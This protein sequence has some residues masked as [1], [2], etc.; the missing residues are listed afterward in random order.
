MEHKVAIN[1]EWAVVSDEQMAS[2]PVEA[3]EQ[4]LNAEYESRVNPLAHFL[5][6]GIKWSDRERQYGHGVVVVPPSEY[7]KEMRNDG[8]A[9]V[10]D[11]TSDYAMLLAPRKTGKSTHGAIYIALRGLKCDPNWPIFA[12]NHVKVPPKWDGKPK[13]AVIASFSWPNVGQLWKV[14]QEFLP[15][16]ELGRYAPNWGSFPGEKGN[17]KSISFGDG[18]PKQITTEVSGLTLIFLCYT[19]R[20]HVWENFKA[21]MLHAD[22]Q[23]P[24]D[25][26]R[27]WQDG[28][29]TMGDYTPACFTL[30]GFC[31]PD[32]PDT[33]GA[34]EL[35]RG[36]WDGH[37]TRGKIVGR[38]HLDVASTPDCIMS[39]KKKKEAFDEYVN[40]KI[41]RSRADERRGHACYYPGWEPGSGL[42]FDADVWQRKLHVINP[43]WD[44][45]KVPEDWTKWRVVDYASS[46][47]VNVCSWF[48]VGPEF[49]VLYRLIYE[50]GLEI[51]DFAELIIRMSY[52]ERVFIEH[53][54]EEGTGNI[55]EYW[56]ERQTH[57]VYYGGT[58]LDPRS[59]SQSQQGQTLVDIFIRYG[60]LDM[61]GACGQRDEIQIPRLKDW[62][63]LDYNKPHPSA[64]D[65]DGK[66]VMGCPRLFFF[67][68]KTSDAVIEMETLRLPDSDRQSS[69]V[70]DK[71]DPSHF[72]DTAK[73]WASDNPSYMGDSARIERNVE[74][75]EANQAGNPYTGY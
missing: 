53:R 44:D 45:D 24:L 16:Y 29:R 52:N 9:F 60:L 28:T 74:R 23:I 54:K 48:A 37:R 2:W 69:G 58:L 35:K 13:T 64:V 57:E 3:R 66:P 59:A 26:L 56:E 5:P 8:T 71:R 32:R 19:Q 25:L 1:G 39:A 20:R 33:G 41:S 15:R 22:E 11:Q 50:R 21:H 42:L 14:Y 70:M 30:S 34:G 65:Y 18:R 55:Y 73:Y 31:L 12:E 47:G 43:L 62:L 72:I 40:P 75:D 36:I 51:H 63:R 67:D 38:Y 27:A 10:S 49:A 61:R 4:L 6:H 46:V 17:P 68:G 7:P